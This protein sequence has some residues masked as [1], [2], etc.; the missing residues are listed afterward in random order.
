MNVFM[1]LMYN[2][3]ILVQYQKI[4]EV[5]MH[6]IKEGIEGTV[7]SYLENLIMDFTL[8]RIICILMVIN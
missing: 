4:I 3:L 5:Y 6:F 2:S 7:S 1:Y 8:E